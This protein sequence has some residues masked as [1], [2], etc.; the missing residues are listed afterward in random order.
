MSVGATVGL[1]LAVLLA[2]AGYLTLVLP[3][4]GTWLSLG[5]TAAAALALVLL[6]L[7]L[8]PWNP[9]APM[10]GLIALLAG[11][12]GWWLGRRAHAARR[13]A[14]RLH[15]RLNRSGPGNS[16]RDGRDGRRRTS[17]ASRKPGEPARR[18]RP[19]IADDRPPVAPAQGTSALDAAAPPA[20]GGAAATGAARDPADSRLE[21]TA[22][23]RAAAGAYERTEALIV[24]RPP[25]AGAGTAPV[26][27]SAGTGP[28]GGT[29]P[30]A[31]GAS[32]APGAPPAP[33]P[34]PVTG[35]ALA[36]LQRTSLGRYRID[37]AIGRGSMGAVY[38]G[39][40]TMLGRQVAIKTMALGQE[41]DGA[42]LQEAKARFFREAETAGR[43]QHRD[44]VTI[45]DVG[46][47]QSLA[48]I[49][50][51]F[52]KGHDLQRHTQPGNLLPVPVVLRI[53]AR[54][55]DALAYAHSQGVV[56]RDVKPANV[57]LHQ[58]TGAVKVTDFGIARVTDASRTRT[59]MVLGTP[60]F[61]SPEHLAG[62]RVD[63]R[64][65]LYSLGVM[66][67]QLLTGRL[68][69][70]AD[71]MAKLMYQIANEPAPPIRSL[72]GELP[73][74]LAAVLARALEKNPADR[75]PDGAQM[76]A[77]LRA[78][79]AAGDGPLWAPAEAG[80]APAGPTPAAGAPFDATVRLPPG[81]PRH[82][83]P[84]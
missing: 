56:H 37:R 82:N 1:G 76:A 45:Y 49:A 23:L 63:G 25:A 26:G 12:Y 54:V 8:T 43:L 51:E 11:H 27:V 18:A 34:R 46:E 83:S 41:F 48:Y 75:H 70:Q 42:E 58:P 53:G 17:G 67:F 16:G 10:L 44:I 3:R 61:M 77:E 31:G 29:Q 5:V 13:T 64:T 6:G 59:G 60:S 9:T 24:G 81:E 39:L 79:D 35:L 72:R 40:D 20:A 66:L 28:L 50:M 2:V 36:D 62:L 68:P 7:V 33:S 15:S 65:D 80:G 55:A 32:A 74:A 57:M 4:L 21:G 22:P 84:P 47:E 71:S 14:S 38:L 19:V 30:V 69:F 73:P 52:L 78:V